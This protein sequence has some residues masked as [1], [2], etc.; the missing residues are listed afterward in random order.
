[1]YISV[2]NLASD[3]NACKGFNEFNWI[4][5]EPPK[6]FH[7]LIVQFVCDVMSISIEK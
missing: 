4:M 7:S 3:M 1:M 2:I 5:S 6:S